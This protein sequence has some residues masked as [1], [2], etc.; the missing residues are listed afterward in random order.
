MWGSVRLLQGRPTTRRSLGNGRAKYDDTSW[1]TSLASMPSRNRRSRASAGLDRDPKDVASRAVEDGRY[2]A[3]PS[4]SSTM[5]SSIERKA[6]GSVAETATSAKIPPEPDRTNPLSR[7]SIVAK[8][9][10]NVEPIL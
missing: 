5:L 1:Q 2:D 9:N 4:V 8:G 6:K 7:L 10:P 3:C